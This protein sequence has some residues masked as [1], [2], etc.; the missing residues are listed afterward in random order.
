LPVAPKAGK[1]PTLENFLTEVIC[2]GDRTDYEYLRNLL[3]WK[4]QNLV[5]NPE[6]AISLRGTSGAGKGTF[7]R[8]L[9]HLFGLKRFVQFLR[10]DDAGAR[11]NAEAEGKL[12]L[13]YDEAFFAHDPKI[14]SRM[15]GEITEPRIPIE[16]K[17][18]NP[19]YV[20]N[21]ALRVY[22]SNEAAS[23]PI[24]QNDRLV[25]V[26]AVSNVHARDRA[27]F[28]KLRKAITG[29][30]M[31][32]FVHDA[33]AA[34]LSEFGSPPPE[35]PKTKARAELPETTAKPEHEFLRELLER[36]KP[37]AG[38]FHWGPQRYPRMNLLKGETEPAEPWRNGQVTVERD[39]LHR[40]YLDWLKLAH[41]R[42][43]TV[44]AAELNAVIQ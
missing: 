35:P 14:R 11:F 24:D 38:E 41:P 42:A 36:G 33:L 3:F 29:E 27:Y 40:A 15:K 17:N 7:G 18:I 16:Y 2:A 1:W 25:L 12:V 5:V 39:A 10:P 20:K 6:V 44:N 26:L 28:A 4:V 32:A 30:E 19:Y 21:L 8:F 13:F 9:E 23:V 31:A 22:A 43:H 34:N 37:P